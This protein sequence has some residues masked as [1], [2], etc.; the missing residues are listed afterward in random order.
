[1]QLDIGNEPYSEQEGIVEGCRT[2][3][4]FEGLWIANISGEFSTEYSQW[5]LSSEFWYF[6]NMTD[7][8]RCVGARRA[9]AQAGSINLQRIQY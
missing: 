4:L 8:K 5:Q 2:V 1:M 7:R 6:G 3:F 9:Y